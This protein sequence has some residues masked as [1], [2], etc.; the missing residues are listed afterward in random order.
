MTKQK[1]NLLTQLTQVVRN[2]PV[3]T[4]LRGKGLLKTRARVPKLEVR[5]ANSQK[6]EIYN[7]V[8]DRYIIGRSTS[9]CDIVVQTP[10]VSQIH[11]ELVR[12]ST[13]AK[14]RFIIRDRDSTNGIFRGRQR[15]KSSPLRHKAIISLGPSELK[16]AAT[17][18]YLDPPPW[19]I[20][21]LQYT[22]IG[23]ASLTALFVAAIAL[24][25]QRV[26]DVRPLPV[27]DQGPV[28]VLAGDGVTSIG[29]A[30][31]EKHTELT[32]L[33]EFG[34]LLPKAIVASEDTSYYWNIGVDPL[35]VLRAVITNARSGKLREGG[36]TI[37]QQLARL[38]L[39]RSYVGTEDSA[40]RKWR[41]AVAAI[42]LT[43]NYSKD[44]LLAIY[45]NRVYLGNGVYGFQDA[46]KLY[47]NKDAS[48]LDLSEAATLAGV[49]PAPN[50]INPF[51]NK[52]LALE[53]R[54]RVLN[55]MAELGLVKEEEAER[56][57][58][59]LLRLNEEAKSKVQGTLAP[60]FYGY[61]FDELQEVLGDNLAKEGNL[62]V[63]TSLDVKMQKVSDASLKRAIAERGKEFDFSQGAIVTLDASNGSI[64][65]MTG[66]VDFKK[67]QFNRASQA[68]RQPGSTFKLFSYTAA[69]NQGIS[70]S[71][72]FSCAPVSSVVGCHNGG[73]GDIDMYRGF[74][75]SE[76]VVAVRVAQAAG[77]KN[78][79]QTARRFG[80]KAQLQETT[81]LVL[82]GYEVTMLEMAGAYGAIANEGIYTQPHAI[83]RVLDGRDCKNSKDI[84]TCRVIF[85]AD[86]DLQP[87]RIVD[88][89][90]ANT[91]ADLMRGTV[92]YGTGRAAAIPQATVV[93]K[94]G[95]T[96]AGRDLWFI[97]F[98]PQRRLLAAVWLGNDEG[99]TG[100]SSGLAAQVW[101]EYMSKVIR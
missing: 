38:L 81:N 70:P 76:N 56:A 46:A 31:V 44:D 67:S 1:P 7:L 24:E 32:K 48:E 66:G 19:Y 22:G 59:S 6:P 42:K 94:T 12:D 58:R 23:L 52:K 89:S 30:D 69:I 62:I 51:K 45:L 40:G 78:V 68:Q 36:S 65:A 21:T 100:G 17:L 74:A 64:L 15:L 4:K 87:R 11:A 101:G 86:K 18:R 5:L 2:L 75:L 96:D 50:A 34:T 27:T 14:A 26:P 84:R 9:K 85:D 92:E 47:F 33:S 13:K 29:P 53:Y 41:E 82:G 49:L 35:G 98:L 83:R 3:A 79:I 99:T 39:G 20:R 43:L 71:T 72:T 97:G 16:D 60:Y 95:T 73:S 90:V 25:F 57:R 88:A 28:E 80:I 10:L 55:R 8:A 91:I 61:V 93:G 37:T 77:L 63:E 54:D